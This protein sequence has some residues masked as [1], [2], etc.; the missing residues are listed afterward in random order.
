MMRWVSKLASTGHETYHL[1]KDDEKILVLT[2]NS[3]SKAARVE[4]TSPKRIFHIKKEGFLRNKTVLCNEYGVKIGELGHENKQNFITIN[5][6]RFFY[7]L[8]NNP[9]AELIVFRESKDKPILSCSL[10]TE[11]GYAAVR[12]SQDQFIDESLNPGLLMA[13][14]W[15]L[16]LPVSKENVPELGRIS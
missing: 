11:N 15:Y 4:C 13:T 12:F 9:L 14:C 3:F 2:L 1:Y 6:Q 8:R 10:V 7:L 5:D 16:F